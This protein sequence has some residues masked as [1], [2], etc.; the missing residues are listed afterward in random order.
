MILGELQDIHDWAKL[1]PKD[2]QYLKYQNNITFAALKISDVYQALCIARANLHFLDNE[3]FGDYASDEISKKFVKSMHIQNSLI[4]YNIAVDYSWQV[5]WLYYD[6]FLNGL[7]PTSKLYE[8]SIKDCNYEELLFGL[9]L[10]NDLKMRDC[11]VKP[12]FGKC[13]SFQQIRP[14]YNYLKHRGTF[15]FDGL[16]ENNSHMMFKYEKNGSEIDLTIV[17]R[18]EINIDKTKNILLDFDKEFVTYMSLLIQIIIPE[19]FTTTTSTLEEMIYGFMNYPM[20]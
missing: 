10:C 6:K 18:K 8:A 14:L 1:A 2:L 4:Y 12:F 5:L 9:T 16:G 3:D 19:H 13:T 20:Q 17:N 11:I 7:N 15:Y